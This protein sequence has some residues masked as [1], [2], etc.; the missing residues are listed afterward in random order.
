VDRHA[1]AAVI[2]ATHTPARQR[3]VAAHSMNSAIDA[4]NACNA[5]RPGDRADLP[6][7]EESGERNPTKEVLD[8]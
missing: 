5:L 1:V 8:C 4:V 6:A 7:G 3:E 2:D